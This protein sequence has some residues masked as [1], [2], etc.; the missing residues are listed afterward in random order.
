SKSFN[1]KKNYYDVILFDSFLHHI[2]NLDEILSKIYFS[3]KKNG[4]FIINE[5]V[6]PNRF[7][8]SSTQ[9]KTSNKALKEL[10][11]KFRKRFGTNN[12]K[13]KIYKP[14][15][16]R[17]ILSDPSEAIKSESI[18]LR[19]KERFNVLEEKPY[20]GNILHLTLKDISQ[21]FI[22]EDDETLNLLDELFVIEDEFLKNSRKSNFIFGVYSRLDK[23]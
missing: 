17:M 8:W 19:V 1:Y 20:G 11:Q 10:P 15:I 4:I 23:N 5:Y 13:S 3:L 9:L 6:G 22:I 16:I 12:V 18:L 14:G 21:N 2:K 7:Q